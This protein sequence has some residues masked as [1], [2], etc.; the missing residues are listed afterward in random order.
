LDENDNFSFLK[1]SIKLFNDSLYKAEETIL[2]I[3]FSKLKSI[4][5][6]FDKENWY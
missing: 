1:S 4:F 2:N 3:I 6:N 5:L